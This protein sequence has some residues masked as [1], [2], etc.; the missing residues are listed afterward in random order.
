MEDSKLRFKLKK[1]IRELS[2]YK[3]RHT[4]LISVYVPTNYNLNLISQQ[5]EN[6]YGTSE[7]IKSKPTRKNVQS[8]LKKIIQQIKL[9]KKNPEN[10]LALFSGNVA[11]NPGVLDYR[12]WAIEPPQPLEIKL[13][14]C[15][16]IFHLDPLI[17]MLE[18]KK[19]YGLIVID[20]Q[21]AS[22]GYLK[23]AHIEI[24][25]D[26][27]SLVPG[28]TRKG[29]QSAARFARVRE[30]LEKDWFKNIAEVV[31]KEFLNNE[32]ITGIILGGPGPAKE[33]FEGFLLE[34]LR[35]KIIAIEGTSYTGTQ[36]LEELVD[37]CKKLLAQEQIAREKELVEKFFD[38]LRKNPNHAAY[39]KAE[40][41][42]A[43]QMK[44]V[45]LLLICEGAPEE[46]F[47][48]YIEQ[49]DREGG[50]WELISTGTRGGNQLSNLG[51]YAAILRFPI[52]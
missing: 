30:G 32:K 35:R 20:K 48:K 6:E 34:P 49:L 45:D 46:E 8:A 44:A 10:G 23:G 40:V 15:D 7:N 19:V 43:L 21:G 25:H 42:K 52:E 12:I 27:T 5:L 4:E 26:D 11:D 1:A 31:K 18:P 47:E 17:K 16:Q 24:I 51:N 3:A 28:K 9:Y 13:Y 41:E 38:V 2:R 36:G 39:G 29:G 37:R 50:K 14:K 22:I 33:E